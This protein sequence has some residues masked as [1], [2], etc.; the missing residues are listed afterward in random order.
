[1]NADRQQGVALITALLVVAIAAVAA[2]SMASRQQLDIRRT[3]G[4]LHGEQA[5]A[6]VN[7]AET[8]ARAVLRRWSPDAV[9]SS[10]RRTSG[11]CGLQK[12]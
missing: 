2:V 7:G 4:L 6:Y 1:M 8:W 3:G 9:A 11:C 10:S 5:W 12:G